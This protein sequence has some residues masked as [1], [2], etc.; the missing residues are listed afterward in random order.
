MTKEQYNKLST[1]IKYLNSHSTRSNI[2]KIFKK[3][4]YVENVEWNKNKYLFVFEDAI[5]DLKE[6]KFLDTNSSDKE[7]WNK[8][9]GEYINETCKW[10]YH[11]EYTT[12][13]ITVARE[14][15]DT[16]YAGTVKP[17]ILSYLMKVISTFLV[18]EN[19][20]EKAYFWLGNGRN[21]K[22]TSTKLIANTLGNYYGELNVEYYTMPSGGPDAPNQNLYNGRRKRLLNTSEVA[23]NDKTDIKTRIINDKFNRITGGDIIQA[24]ELGS[25]NIAQFTPGCVLFQLNK[26]CEFNKDINEDDMSLRERIVIIPFPY[27]FTDDETKIAS[28]PEIYKR[29][30]NT[31]KD[32]FASGVYRRAMFDIMAE[33][34]KNYLKD[35]LKIPE[36]VKHHTNTY[37][38]SQNILGWF[39]SQYEYTGR[40]NDRV[41]LRIIQENYKSETNINL[42]QATLR[43]KLEKCGLLIV[44]SDGFYQVK[45]YLQTE[46]S[47]PYKPVDNNNVAERFNLPP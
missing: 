17:E 26:M 37:F 39:N 18:Q 12:E 20:E 7:T 2:L 33:N 21:S 28:E 41:S 24:R 6:G 15:I 13:Q 32:K 40:E 31:F 11:G 16:F 10:N 25:K 5:Y 43:E 22:G 9:K 19:K 29:K 44:K 46:F 23:Q 8:I 35:G 34:Y 47:G 42:S 36:M 30:D 3:D 1:T 14:D 4:N 27:S 45:G 38:R